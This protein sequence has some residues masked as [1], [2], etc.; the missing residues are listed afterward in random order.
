MSG[1]RINQC[2]GCDELILPGD[3]LAPSFGQ[4]LHFECG[5]RSIIGSVGH[6]KK[7]CSCYGGT[8]EDPPGMTRREAAKAAMEYFYEHG[9]GR[10]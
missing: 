4:P 2:L 6:Q 9:G 5:L 10:D 8:E 7:N 3:R 1:D